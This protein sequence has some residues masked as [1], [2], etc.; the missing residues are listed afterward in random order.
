MK[1]SSKAMNRAFVI[2]LD[3]QEP[4]FTALQQEMLAYGLECERFVVTPDEHKQI[5]CTMSHLELIARAKKEGWPYLI[6]L[7]DDCMTRKA[8]KAW[9]TVFQYLLKEKKRWDIFLGGAMYVHP[10]KLQLDFKK[11]GPIKIEII[12][13]QH[14]VAAHFIIYNQ[15]SYDRLLQWYELPAPLAKRPNIDNLYDKFQLRTWAASPMLAWQKPRTGNDFT[16]PL[17]HAENKLSHFAQSLRRCLKYRLFGR[18]LRE[19]Q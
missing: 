3:S 12:E 16:T 9:P 11:E 19:I 18:W 7:E 17:Q 8:M 2:N 4:L 14:A 6:V 15:T 1:N 13:C 10:K 5:G